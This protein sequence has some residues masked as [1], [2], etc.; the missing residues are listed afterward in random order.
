MPSKPGH[1]FTN[2]DRPQLPATIVQL[3]S[4]DSTDLSYPQRSSSCILRLDRPQLPATI[5][6]LHSNDS[7]DLS[8]LQ[9][10][11]SCILRLN[12]PQ[13]PAT[14]I[15]L[16]SMT[17]PTSASLYDR[18]AAFYD[19]TGSYPHQTSSCISTTQP[20]ATGIKHSAAHIYDST[21]PAIDI[22]HLAED[23]N[24]TATDFTHAFVIPTI[25]GHF[26]CICHFAFVSF[27]VF[28]CHYSHALNLNHLRGRH[29]YR[30]RNRSAIVCCGFSVSAVICC[31]KFSELSLRFLLFYCHWFKLVF[32]N[33]CFV[34]N[35][36]SVCLS[37]Y[38]KLAPGSPLFLFWF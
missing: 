38:P 14:I 4:N 8:F 22:T 17:W 27:I 36:I 7:T 3:H 21:I 1:R 11:S 15:Q 29:A 20:T 34:Y 10:S 28:G 25:N 16:H 33:T 24:T 2:H 23:P 32:G 19:S 9:R 12:R 5:V 31:G 13:L 6:Q 26:C 18:P 35:Y 37:F 30:H